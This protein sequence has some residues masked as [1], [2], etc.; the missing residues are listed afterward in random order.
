M[1]QRKNGII[2]IKGMYGGE[3]GKRAEEPVAKEKYPLINGKIK[4]QW[5]LNKK[6]FKS[7]NCA[8]SW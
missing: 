5:I 7:I 8:C 6:C 3:R 1:G 2:L 4:L